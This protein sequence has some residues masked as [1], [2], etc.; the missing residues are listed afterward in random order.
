L[1]GVA[2]NIGHPCDSIGEG[3]LEGLGYEKII[4]C[5]ASVCYPEFQFVVDGNKNF[6][7]Y[8]GHTTGHCPRLVNELLSSSEV[9]MLIKLLEIIV[10]NTEWEE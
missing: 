8:D 2:Q 3:G 5:W 6:V 10:F 7:V 1:N 4:L 9:Y